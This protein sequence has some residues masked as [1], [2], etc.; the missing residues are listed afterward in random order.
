MFLLGVGVGPSFPFKF[1]CFWCSFFG[2]RVWQIRT[3]LP[4][5]FWRRKPWELSWPSL[6]SLR[7]FLIVWFGMDLPQLSVQ[8]KL[9]P[10][11]QVYSIIECFM[12]W[13]WWAVRV[14]RRK[15]IRRRKFS[16]ILDNLWQPNQPLL[17]V[18]D[19][20]KRLVRSSRIIS[21]TNQT[22]GFPIRSGT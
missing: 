16:F 10:E 1:F 19:C 9:L 15:R 5:S 14:P 2:L 22:F 3:Q 13:L 20:I 8:L 18:L 17:S 4:F 12:F 21:R 11:F 6:E 7:H